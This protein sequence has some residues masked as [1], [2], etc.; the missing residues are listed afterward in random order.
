M[1]ATEG[2]DVAV[3]REGLKYCI[4]VIKYNVTGTAWGSGGNWCHS[5]PFSSRIFVSI[6]R[7]FF[8]HSKKK[9]FGLFP[10]A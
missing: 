7:L 1:E 5:L 4:H 2:D 9:I 3:I 10:C 6:P 8:L